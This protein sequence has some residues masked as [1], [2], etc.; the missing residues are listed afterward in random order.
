M[1]EALTTFFTF[2]ARLPARA[3][4]ALIWVY[5]R[6]LSPVF[7]I[8]LG[9]GCGCRFYPSCS[10]YA[11]E[12]VRTHG[13]LAGAWLA[14]K[15]LAKCQPLHR[16]GYDPVPARRKVTSPRT[17]ARPHSSRPVCTRA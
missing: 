16:G 1:P 6:T 5:Q 15:R 17:L 10:H 11:A 8:V 12:A 2:L 3:L 9:P 13:A 4:L 14:L 7:P